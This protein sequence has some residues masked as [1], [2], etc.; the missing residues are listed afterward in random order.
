MNEI[1]SSMERGLFDGIKFSVERI[2]ALGFPLA[3]ILIQLFDDT[4]INSKLTDID[5]SLICEKLGQVAI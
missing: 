1:W 4:I 3:A 5:K 2:I